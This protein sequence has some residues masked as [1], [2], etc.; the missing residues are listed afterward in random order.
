MAARATLSRVALGNT[1]TPLSGAQ[2]EQPT[3][4]VISH[5]SPL[6]SPGGSLEKTRSAS[7]RQFWTVVRESEARFGD[8]STCGEESPLLRWVTSTLAIEY[9]WLATCIRQRMFMI[10][11]TTNKE[12]V[13]AL[14]G[15]MGEENLEELKSVIASERS[16][17]RTVL[18]LKDVTLVDQETVQYLGRCE[19]K[20]VELKNCPAY[21]REWIDV[22]RKQRA[23]RKD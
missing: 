15:R 12:V 14:I 3:M 16:E 17:F 8:F 9:C 19:R 6:A 1:F 20:H 2:K 13:L 18:D 4:T 7:L 5:A 21:I 11:R 22:T 23:R 10:R